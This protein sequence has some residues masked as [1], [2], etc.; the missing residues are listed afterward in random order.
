M[1][2]GEFIRENRATLVAGLVMA[3]LAVAVFAVFGQG[4]SNAHDLVARVH[5]G[6]GGVRELALDVDD[7][8]VVET[9]LGRNVIVVKDGEAYVAEA[10]CPH[11]DCLHQLPIS[12]P[13][14]QLICLPHELWVEVVERGA[15]DG[16][17]D[18]SAVAT[19]DGDQG[20]DVVSR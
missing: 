14:Q 6:D 1:R 10:D 4:G 9:S 13:G 20:V 18:A 15:T 2:L 8:L 5:D 17:L 3:A 7:T 11:G 16:E 12:S 19:V